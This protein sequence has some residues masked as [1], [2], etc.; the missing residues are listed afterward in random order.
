MIIIMKV[1]PGIILFAV[2][3][4]ALNGCKW[5]SSQAVVNES[6]QNS[7]LHHENHNAQGDDFF[8]DTGGM[9]APAMGPMGTG[10]GS[11]A[12]I[13]Q[14]AT[15]MLGQENCT[16]FPPKRLK[17]AQQASSVL[18]AAGVRIKGS[19][20]VNALVSQLRAIGWVDGPCGPGSVKHTAGVSPIRHIGVVGANNETIH[21]SSSQGSSWRCGRLST[22]P[23]PKWSNRARCLNPPN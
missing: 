15:S 3:A 10:N 22:R 13:A 4:I 8:R 16:L 21:N 6:A 17:C 1:G 11:R 18:K 7:S 2:F 14:T 23:Y 19:L 9:T 20:S 12:T 5:A